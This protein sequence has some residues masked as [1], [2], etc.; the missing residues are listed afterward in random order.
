M[1]IEVKNFG[2]I[3]K[4]QIDLDKKVT[5]FVGYN[6]TGKTYMSQFIWELFFNDTVLNVKPTESTN[7]NLIHDN[8]L[9]ITSDVLSKLVQEIN[10]NLSNMILP[11]LFGVKSDFFNKDNFSIKFNII[12]IL[13]IIKI[14][15]FK[16]LLVR[17]N[18][19]YKYPLE[20]YYFIEK[21][22]NSLELKLLKQDIE[23]ADNYDNYVFEN[24]RMY[25]LFSDSL[26]NVIHSK[27]T[28]KQIFDTVIFNIFKIVFSDKN[29]RLPVFLPANRIFFPSYYKYIYSTIK[30]EKEQI[31]KRIKYKGTLESIKDLTKTP[32]TKPVNELIKMVYDLNN[33]RI[34]KYIYDDLLTG[35]EEIIGGKIIIKSVAGIA[36]IEFYLKMENGEELEM[37]MASSAANQLATLYLYFQYWA[38]E[39][40]NFLII[41][42]PEENLHPENQI[43]LINILMKFADRNNNKLLITTHSPI[44]TDM[45]NN[46][47][48]LC[49][50]KTEGTDIEKLISENDL[51]MVQ[52]QNI[53]RKDFGIY[54]FNEGTIK[55]YE[56]GD[57]GAF[58]K[59]FQTEQ[60][61]IK[62]VSNVL[63][64]S[65]YLNIQK[66]AR[67]SLQKK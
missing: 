46:Y 25:E 48:N 5:V 11:E 13:E 17:H 30:D 40:D 19:I 62:N 50:L 58:F 41:D 22:K 21:Q 45:I 15:P 35:L 23:E 24:K 60:D 16:F 59:D 52:V 6:N 65:I 7:D 4:G 1:K 51:N 53:E 26:T 49:E 47:A 61:K 42:E 33:Y 55:E 8:T 20:G 18:L 28:D 43:K 54:F 38:Y 66:N 34:E 3:K 10:F 27:Y 31:D 2:K 14:M 57:Y 36:P 29:R 56:Q 44:I 37:Y 9:T 12:D 39:K 64:D 63:E 32:Y 67:K